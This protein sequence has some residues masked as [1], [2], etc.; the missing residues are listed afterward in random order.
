MT[1]DALGALRQC[2]GLVTGSHVVYASGK[3]GSA[4]LNKDAIYPRTEIVGRLCR[5]LAAGMALRCGNIEA[6]VAPEK[7]G[8]IL[9]QWVAHHLRTDAGMDVLA[10]YAE[11]EGGGFAF[12]RGYDE[13][14]RGRPVAV[15]E[16]VLTTG[17]S[18]LKVIG[19]LRALGCDVRVVGA[20]FNRGGVTNEELGVP[21]LVSLANVS[22]ESFP[23]D[24]CPL[25]QANV[26]I[27]VTVGKGRE[28]LARR[29]SPS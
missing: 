3:H 5:G 2:G 19:A 12:R 14:V 16:D 21:R 1:T 26:P 25:C 7:G 23:E 29:S 17:G 11:K 9:S 6:V 15:V 27:N 13:L 8:I 20:L 28:F 18:V 22:L 24:D 10:V 4:Y